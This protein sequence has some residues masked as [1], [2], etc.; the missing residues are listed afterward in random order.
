M[1]KSSAAGHA[2]HRLHATPAESGR[3][4]LSLLRSAISRQPRITVE[5]RRVENLDPFKTPILLATGGFAG[6]K[7]LLREFLPEVAE[8][9]RQSQVEQKR[10]RSLLQILIREQK[11]VRVNE[12][13]V[14]HHSAVRRLKEM[15]A[16]HRAERFG[17]PTFK[18]WTG[19]SRKYAIPLLEYL[20]R[21]RVTQRDGN[22][23]IEL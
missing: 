9:L 3:E 11:L 7:A 10:S 14:F 18:D 20:D 12:E 16:G 6:N 15:L 19:I 8:A 21:E 13:L 5:E 22:E 4:L 1:T 17:V 2:V 23:R